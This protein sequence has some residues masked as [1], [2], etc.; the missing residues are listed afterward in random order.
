MAENN[1]L[2]STLALLQ[3]KR[4][5]VFLWNAKEQCFQAM[6]VL[7]EHSPEQIFTGFL[8]NRVRVRSDGAVEIELTRLE[9]LQRAQRKARRRKPAP[10]IDFKSRA[11]GEREP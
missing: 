5:V 3:S 6:W 7:D 4:V 11:A 8:C 9:D 2:N 10:P 1:S